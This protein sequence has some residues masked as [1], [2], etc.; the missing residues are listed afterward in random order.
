MIYFETPFISGHFLVRLVHRLLPVATLR[1]LDRVALR[2]A[3]RKLAH[4]LCMVAR[5][6]T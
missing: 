6:R 1:A 3:P 5:R 2:V 4:Q